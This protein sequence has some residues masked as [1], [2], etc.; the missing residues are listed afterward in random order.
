MQVRLFEAGSA[1]PPNADGVVNDISCEALP[2]VGDIVQFEGKNGEV[3]KRYRVVSRLFRSALTGEA[4]E[5]AV[6]VEAVD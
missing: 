3:I 6:E 2:L 4:T 1:P 5:M